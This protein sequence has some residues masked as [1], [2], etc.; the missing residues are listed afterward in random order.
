MIHHISYSLIA[1][2]EY[3]PPE[4]SVVSNKVHQVQRKCPPLSWTQARK[5]VGHWSTASSISDCSKPRHTCSRRCCSL[6]LS[7]QWRHIYVMWPAHVVQWSNHLAPCAVERDVRSGRGSIRASARARPPT[8]RI[9]SNNSY[10]HYDQGD[11]PGQENRGLDG[12]LY[13]LWPFISDIAIFV[14]K[15]DVKLS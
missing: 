13:K 2:L 5:R 15:R 10:A 1:L 6:S 4:S 7:W 9:I 14:L 11:N 12:V 8:K 3:Y